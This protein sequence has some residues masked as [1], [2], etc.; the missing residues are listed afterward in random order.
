MDRPQIQDCTFDKVV[1]QGSS[2]PKRLVEFNG[3]DFSLGELVHDE[4]IGKQDH[5]RGKAQLVFSMCVPLRFPPPC[6]FVLFFVVSLR[7]FRYQP[8]SAAT[9][10]VML[11]CLSFS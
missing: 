4:I 5:K 3:S 1:Q 9:T 8:D 2:L 11:Y 10:W 6:E 7:C